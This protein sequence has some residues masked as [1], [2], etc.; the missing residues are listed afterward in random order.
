MN[1]ENYSKM[2]IDMHNKD[3]HYVF[4]SDMSNLDEIRGLW[5]EQY[6]DAQTFKNIDEFVK[7]MILKYANKCNL[8]YV[9]D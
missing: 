7:F 1:I 4:L 2:L 5:W 6:K 9:T 3:L 8:Y